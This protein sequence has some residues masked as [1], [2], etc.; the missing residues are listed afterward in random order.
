MTTL[1]VTLHII[2]CLSLIVVVLLQAGKGAEMG[3][4]FGS[5]SSQ[6]LLGPSGGQ[7]MMGK[8]TTGIAIMFMLTSL[9]L[10]YM[11]GNKQESSV[12]PATTVSQPAAQETPAE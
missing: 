6:A 10:A 1:L 8:V 4:A 11:S 9:S 5:G 7:S 12:M 2:I 3:A